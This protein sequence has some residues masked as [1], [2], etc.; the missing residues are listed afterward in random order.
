MN[1]EDGFDLLFARHGKRL[2]SRAP[3]SED[4]SPPHCTKTTSTNTPAKRRRRLDFNP[5]VDMIPFNF[6]DNL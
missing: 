4:P 6:T 2:I 5:S 3:L 1:G